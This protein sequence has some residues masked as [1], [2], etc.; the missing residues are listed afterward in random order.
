PSSGGTLRHRPRRSSDLWRF[1]CALA[2][3]RCNLAYHSTSTV[4]PSTVRVVSDIPAE[5]GGFAVSPNAP[6]EVARPRDDNW[7][8]VVAYNFLKASE[9]QKRVLGDHLRR[10]HRRRLQ[11][12]PDAFGRL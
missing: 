5:Q 3:C 4:S 6:Q 11:C 9:N 8:T 12:A 1:E 7:V 10:G 2:S